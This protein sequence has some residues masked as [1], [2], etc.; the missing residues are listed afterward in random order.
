[1]APLIAAMTDARANRSTRV[2]C[3]ES[4][5]EDL[6]NKTPRG[7]PSAQ[8]TVNILGSR[9]YVS[10]ETGSEGLTVLQ[11]SAVRQK[12]VAHGRCAA[13]SLCYS[14]LSGCQQSRQS[15]RTQSAESSLL[16]RFQRPASGDRYSGERS[17]QM[18]EVK[19]KSGVIDAQSLQTRCN[20]TTMELHV[21]DCSGLSPAH[22]STRCITGAS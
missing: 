9:P 14:Q 5:A 18:I 6:L 22:G 15:H 12:L 20:I 8:F 19:R 11:H 10:V 4:D 21:L 16:T 13:V 1:M 3:L 7:G 2:T 17:V